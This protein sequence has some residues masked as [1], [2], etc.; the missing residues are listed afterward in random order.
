[1]RS[2][3]GLFLAGALAACS[4]SPANPGTTSSGTGGATSTTTSAHG[5]AGG[6]NLGCGQDPAL[7]DQEKQ[8]VN[9]PADTWLEVPSTHFGDFCAAHEP[10][11]AHDVQGC[12]AI[13]NAW[14]GGAWDPVHRR[15][16]LWGGGH[17]DYFGNEVYGFSTKTFQWELLVEGSAVASAAALTEPMADG[18]PVSRHTYDGLAYLTQANR[19]FAFG[20]A[21]SPQGGSSHLTWSL[22]LDTKAWKQLAVTQG[23]PAGTSQYFMGSAYDEADQRVYMR[24]QDGV[25]V[26]EVAG[27]TWTRLLDAGYPPLY[28]EWSQWH[29]RRGVFDPKRKLFFTLGGTTA[30]GKPEL[31]AFDVTTSQAV[32]E[33]WVTSGGDDI[34]S[35]NA[36]G[37]DLDT[38]ADAI[39]AWNGGAARVLDLASKAWSTKSA[40]GAPGKAVEAGTYG[41]FRYIAVYNV[42]VLVNQA[43]E[44]VFFYKHTGGCGP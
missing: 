25:W 3:V 41:R 39:V 22:D 18:T 19:M 1:M 5:G 36:P 4:S 14:G 7:S 15:M 44:N 17:N 8:L 12:G 2:P 28:P 26:Y 23:L 9:L 37:A 30:S 21:T 42:F 31:F 6:V 10:A 40:A 27:D 35:S 11:G 33:A 16:I 29:Y 34:V 32:H 20:G 24:N 43:S 38:A 13:I